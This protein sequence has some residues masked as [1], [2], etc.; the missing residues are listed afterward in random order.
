MAS[1]TRELR[2]LDSAQRML[3]KLENLDE[4][5]EIWDKAEALRLYAKSADLGFK[6]QNQAAEVK[7]RA[8]RGAGEILAALGLRGGDRKSASKVDGVS[9]VDRGSPLNSRPVGS[10]NRLFPRKR[11][12]STSMRQSGKGEN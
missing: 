3:A 9:L 10:V 6:A 12:S 11:S 8:E 5:K 4:I 2:S 7:L 1:Q